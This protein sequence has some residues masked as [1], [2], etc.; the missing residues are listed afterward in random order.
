MYLILKLIIIGMIAS[1]SVA[2]LVS[3]V[4]ARM[5]KARYGK[6]GVGFVDGIQL[7]NLV[8][9]ED[10][11]KHRRFRMLFLSAGWN[12]TVGLFYVIKFAIALGILVLSLMIA[13]TNN[14]IQMTE[15]VTN[16]NY[17][18]SM[19]DQPIEPT[20]ALIKQEGNLLT[21]F[22]VHLETLGVSPTNPKANDIAGKYIETN[23]ITY[24]SADILATRLVGKST[25]IDHLE[26]NSMQLLIIL[27]LAIACYFAPNILLAVKLEFVKNNRD[28]QMINCLTTYSVMGRLPPYR[29]DSV[30]KSMQ[31][32]SDIYRQPFNDF[33]DVL[34]RNKVNELDDIV[35]ETKD[36][37]LSQMFEMLI[38]GSEIGINNTVENVDDML[39]MKVKWLDVNAAKKRQSKFIMSFIPVGIVMVLLYTYALQGL[40]VMN[41]LM[42]M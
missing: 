12:I 8:P 30:I 15:V 22:R 42:M 24:D 37:D 23:D 17:G 25:E 39:D 20:A 33:K 9:G 1:L 21:R 11:P 29:V 7:Y 4:K 3:M 38:L 16:L 28:W 2:F 35:M 26:E 32:V 14:N 6:S 5:M 41:G 27:F 31:D 18:R 36:D 10:N 34:D 19:M 40:S 13:N